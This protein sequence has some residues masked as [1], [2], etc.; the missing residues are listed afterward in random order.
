MS[1]PESISDVPETLE[2][3]EN[4]ARPE[5]E[6]QKQALLDKTKAVIQSRANKKQSQSTRAKYLRPGFDWRAHGHLV[7]SGILFSLLVLYVVA[8]LFQGLTQP[9]TNEPRELTA[10]SLLPRKVKYGGEIVPGRVFVKME[11]TRTDKDPELVGEIKKVIDSGGMPADVFHNDIP[12][13]VNV[14]NELVAAFEVYKENPGELEQ[15]RAKSPPSPWKIDGDT[16]QEVADVMSRTDRKR[17]DIRKMLG[18]DD[19]CFAFNF[20]HD[21]DYGDVPDT[22][23]SD[24][25]SDYLLL[26]EF[27]A[28]RALETKEVASA[29]DSLAYMFRMA[30]LAAEVKNVNIRTRASEIRMRAVDVMQGVVLNP[31]FSEQNLIALLDTLQ[32]QLD[33]WTPESAMWIG[34]RASGLVVYN[35]IRQHGLDSALEPEEIAE[36][37]Q[38][39]IYETFSSDL[40]RK[41][42]QDQTT[43]M[44]I[45]QKIIEES[46][47]PYY[48]R[49]PEWKKIETE[50]RLRRGMS[51]EPV[52][53][54]ILL[55]GV[56]EIM[57][58]CAQD[59]AKCEM[60]VLAM[61]T[62]LGRPIATAKRP[63]EKL[64]LDPLFGQK[65]EITQLPGMVQVSYFSNLKPFQV[66]KFGGK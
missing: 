24:F 66:P 46:S 37:Q 23:A 16:L 17:L 26:E 57:Q 62:S 8:R 27:A 14:A 15:L 60:A 61:A 38:R 29:V 55:R 52:I 6:T 49:V 20:V 18:K 58:Y 7:I 22:S 5:D 56:S 31:H 59:R 36:L 33:A 53:A 13:E 51:D 21:P 39:G 41:L 44:R 10:E 9:Q 32:E 3:A 35:L 64:E 11:A 34:D 63:K 25:L 45:M 48:Q 43:Y 28:A 40:L 12:P 1:E 2:S 54:E 42:P 50:L 4:A 65:Y 47:K 19:V 30:Q